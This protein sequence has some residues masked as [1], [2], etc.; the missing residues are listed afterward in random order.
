M[1]SYAQSFFNYPSLASDVPIKLSYLVC[2]DVLSV[3]ATSAP[4]PEFQYCITNVSVLQ[5]FHV[6]P[7]GSKY[8]VFY[9]TPWAANM[10]MWII[11]Y[12]LVCI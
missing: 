3:S 4:D 12:L 7:I 8:D 2:Q 5:S 6:D 1:A 9:W 10:L 11:Q